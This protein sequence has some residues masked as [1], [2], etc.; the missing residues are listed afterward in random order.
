M[1]LYIIHHND[2][3]GYAGA[4]LVDKYY[5]VPMERIFIEMDYSK[6]ISRTLEEVTPEDHI[7]IVDFSLKPIEMDVLLSKTKNVTW[8]DH[9]KT[10]IDMYENY[11]KINDIYGIQFIG[12]SGSGLTWLYFNGW[13]KTVLEELKISS[14]NDEE[15]LNVLNEELKS[16]P[17]WLQLVDDWDTWKSKIREAEFFNLAV[18]NQLTIDLFKKLDL[19]DQKMLDESLPFLNSLIMKGENFAEFRAQW[20]KRFMKEYGFEIDLEGNRVFCVNGGSMNSKYYNDLI[21]EYD[22]VM[23][24]CFNSYGNKKFK[25]SIYSEKIDVSEIAKKFGGGGHPGASGFYFDDMNF[26]YE[27]MK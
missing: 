8:I 11:D 6:D 12:I 24:F 3:D 19:E 1:K 20:S 10:A 15:A 2:S 5:D 22:A 23:N 13:S 25:V 17:Y 27:R 14:V 7:F 26:I 4:Y 21:E 16:A 18:S 9:H